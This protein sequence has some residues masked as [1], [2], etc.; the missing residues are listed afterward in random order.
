MTLTYA[1]NKDGPAILQ[2]KTIKQKEQK[3]KNEIV[4][5]EMCYW[6]QARNGILISATWIRYVN[7]C[8][9]LNTRVTKYS[10]RPVKD[11]NNIQVGCMVDSQRPV[12]SVNSRRRYTSNFWLC[13]LF[14]KT[15]EPGNF[16]PT[17]RDVQ[18]WQGDKSVVWYQ[19]S[20]TYH[21]WMVNMWNVDYANVS[22]VLI[23]SDK[24]INL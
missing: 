13:T 16:T 15:K 2:N 7:M 18:S 3:A 24:V 11:M 21:I 14:H 5:W 1:H 17:Y 20:T 23:L 19:A 12:D 4:L 22:T 9:Y 6:K 10:P 8:I